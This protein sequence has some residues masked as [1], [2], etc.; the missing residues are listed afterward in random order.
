MGVLIYALKPT[1]LRVASDTWEN[2]E[3]KT[4]YNELDENDIASVFLNNQDFKPIKHLTKFEKGLWEAEIDKDGASISISYSSYHD[5]K[6]VVS[7]LTSKRRVT[8]I[9]HSTYGE[10]IE[11][12]P[13]IEMLWFTD[14]DGCFDYVIA[15]RLYEDFKKY[16]E[17]AKAELDEWNYGLYDNYMKILK[18]CID[19]K[20]VVL[21][22]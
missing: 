19:I 13:F 22:H 18:E 4:V 3:V 5:F 15:E 8:D 2:E 11:E 20:G 17:K 9:L 7:S 12:T 21:Y 10:I 1:K 14:C 16:H 6:S